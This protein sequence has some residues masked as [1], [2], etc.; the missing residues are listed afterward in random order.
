MQHLTFIKDA[1]HD[2]KIRQP[3]DWSL[4][5]NGYTLSV[6]LAMIPVAIFAYWCAQ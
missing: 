5:I 2:A 4:V 6:V 3:F 1:R